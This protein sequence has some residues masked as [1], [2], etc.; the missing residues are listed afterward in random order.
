MDKR[1]IDWD[2]AENMWLR[3]DDILRD[4]VEDTIRKVI[5]FNEDDRFVFT[6][7]GGMQEDDM[8]TVWKYGYLNDIP[9]K[10]RGFEIFNKRVE[11]L[12][13]EGEDDETSCRLISINPTSYEEMKWAID[14]YLQKS[15][16]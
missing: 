5:P 16:K 4:A 1:L 9:Y 10:L 7:D 2:N 3:A 11:V 15:G 14:D 8:H 6:E 13:G 12:L